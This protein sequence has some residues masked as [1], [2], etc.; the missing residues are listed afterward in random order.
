MRYIT[1]CMLRSMRS[2]VILCLL[3][4]EPT[5]EAEINTCQNSSLFLTQKMQLDLH[6]LVVCLFL[7]PISWLK[8][9]A[10]ICTI[11]QPQLVEMTKTRL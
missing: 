11:M 10:N 1:A 5:S 9:L 2:H 8:C 6:A 7:A 4:H 3:H